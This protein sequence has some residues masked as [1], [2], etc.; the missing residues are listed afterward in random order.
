MLADLWQQFFEQIGLH[1]GQGQ[2]RQHFVGHGGC[3]FFHQ[4]LQGR[5]GHGPL[6]ARIVQTAQNFQN[7]ALKLGIRLKAQVIDRRLQQEH[8]FT[9]G[10]GRLGVL[11]QNIPVRDD[12]VFRH[13]AGHVNPLHGLEISP[14]QQGQKQQRADQRPQAPTAVMPHFQRLDERQDASRTRRLFLRGHKR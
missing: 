13:L 9:A 4:A 3:Q 1:F 6:L 8:L 14:G 12:V 7:P 11:H 2:F 10:L 5:V